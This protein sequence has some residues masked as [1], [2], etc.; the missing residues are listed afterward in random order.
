MEKRNTC[1]KGKRKK[2]DEEPKKKVLKNKKKCIKMLFRK[3]RKKMV[4]QHFS[5]LN[6]RKFIADRHIVRIFL[7]LPS[8]SQPMLL[9]NGSFF[10]GKHTHTHTQRRKSC[11][12]GLEREKY[13]QHKNGR[14]CNKVTCIE[15]KYYG[16]LFGNFSWLVFFVVICGSA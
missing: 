3:R 15:V 7:L 10:R 8:P 9:S 11:G 12:L 13:I 6:H 16:L 1:S 2:T 5:T 4:Q 14:Q